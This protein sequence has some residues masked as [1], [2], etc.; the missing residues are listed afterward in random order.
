MGHARTPHVQDTVFLDIGYFRV[1][2]I[3]ETGVYWKPG[4]RDTVQNEGQDTGA[5]P[6]VGV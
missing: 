6:D 2:G 5:G 3:L 1:G 4:C